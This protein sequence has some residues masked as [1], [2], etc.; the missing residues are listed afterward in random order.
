MKLIANAPAPTAL[1][2]SGGKG[3]V[4]VS[5]EAFSSYHASESETWERMAL[6]RAR[7]V[8]GDP[9]FA[10]DVDQSLLATY[11]RDVATA[12]IAKDIRAM[13]QLVAMEKPASSHW[14]L[15]LAAGGLVDIEFA[16]QFLLLKYGGENSSILNPNIGVAL[17]S[18]CAA[19]CLSPASTDML[20]EAW[21]LQ[22]RL[23]QL[24]ALGER[25]PFEPSAARAPFLKRLVKAA[26]LPDFASLDAS[27]KDLQQKAHVTM[28]DILKG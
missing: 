7:V 23:V 21:R 25:L 1:R 19:Q 28:L 18:L 17:L 3:P 4:A 8:A 10:V 2:P 26:E 9:S 16:V 22:S 12:S 11:K 15:K 20:L 27:L 24:L 13:R 5:L 6:T 14:D